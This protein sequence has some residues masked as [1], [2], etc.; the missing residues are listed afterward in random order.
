MVLYMELFTALIIVVEIVS[1][2]NTGG[3]DKTWNESSV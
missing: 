3:V 2:F 1:S